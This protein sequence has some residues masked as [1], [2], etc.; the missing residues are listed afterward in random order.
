MPETQYTLSRVCFLRLAPSYPNKLVE[1]GHQLKNTG[2]KVILVHPTMVETAEAAAAICGFPKD[3][4]FLFSDRP[5]GPRGGI[6]DW[7]EMLGTVEE[8]SR[9]QW[10]PMT[11]EESKKSVATVNY[12]SGTTG[13]PKGVCVSHLNIISN[14]EQHI[15]VKYN[16]LPY[17]RHNRPH[18]SMVGF[19]PLYHAYGQMWAMVMAV[20]LNIPI[21]IMEKFNYAL[22]L[23]VIQTYKI[24]HLQVAPP[25]LIM[26]SKRPETSQ[27]DISSVKHILCG[28]APLK[29]ELQ[30][31][32]TKRFGIR[33][34]QG[35][36]MTEVTTGA[37]FVPFHAEDE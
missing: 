30:N 32:I 12:S 15:F 27:Y 10:K 20:K 26:L 8:A 7:R 6:K 25:I 4:I 37:L 1:L 34:T 21:Y 11:P 33:V 17:A 23:K 14:A 2:A 3:H 9:Y 22:F 29:K 5:Q 18:E 13:L 24:T 28:A 31:H 19:L 16:G 35:W 36:G